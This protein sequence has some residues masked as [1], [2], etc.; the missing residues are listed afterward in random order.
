MFNDKFQEV[1]AF[2]AP[3]NNPP[4]ITANDMVLEFPHGN[5]SLRVTTSK[6]WANSLDVTF[7]KTSPRQ[8]FTLTIREDRGALLAEFFKLIDTHINAGGK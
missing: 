3:K 6:D 5:G 7:F 1:A 2:Y 8:E 4:S